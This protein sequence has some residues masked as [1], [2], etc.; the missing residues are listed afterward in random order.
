MT[1][2]TVYAQIGVGEIQI[3]VRVHLARLHDVSTSF[4]KEIALSF[5]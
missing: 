3:V 2:V 1:V 4:R 5:K